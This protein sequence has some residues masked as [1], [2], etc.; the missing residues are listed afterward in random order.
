MSQ[1]VPN[2]QHYVAAAVS[3]AGGGETPNHRQRAVEL[4]ARQAKLEPVVVASHIRGPSLNMHHEGQPGENGARDMPRRLRGLVGRVLSLR[5]GMT[6]A[7][8]VE[9]REPVAW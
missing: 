2:L 7:R 6:P 1:G 8:L 3:L 9:C 5:G 4:T